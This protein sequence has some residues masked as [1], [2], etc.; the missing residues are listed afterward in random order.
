MARTF[1]FFY[2]YTL[3]FALLSVESHPVQDI[4]LVFLITYGII[5]IEQ[6]TIEMDDPFGVHPCDLPVLDE[7]RSVFEDV[8]LSVLDTDG[9]SAVSQ[10]QSRM[11]GN[12]PKND[13][14][15]ATEMSGLLA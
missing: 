13:V 5:G 14:V 2:T 11:H 3:P 9:M 10:L 4:V 1:L 8:Y 7:M 15:Q 12:T 6:I